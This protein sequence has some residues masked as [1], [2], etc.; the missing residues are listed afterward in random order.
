M[1]SN[2]IKSNEKEK[3]VRVSKKG[4]QKHKGATNWALLVAEEKKDGF[5]K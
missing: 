4:K 1:K 2:N 5:R 3:V